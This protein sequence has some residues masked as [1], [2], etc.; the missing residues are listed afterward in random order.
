MAS[1]RTLLLLAVAAA[2][3]DDGEIAFKRGD[4]AQTTLSG[5]T[6]SWTLIASSWLDSYEDSVPS[7]IR[8]LGKFAGPASRAVTWRQA[9]FSCATSEGGIARVLPTVGT[10]SPFLP[11]ATLASMAEFLS[12]KF[13]EGCST[14]LQASVT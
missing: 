10:A 1:T 13:D 7:S 11:W 12:S 3:Q 8:A 4:D 6:P 2:A 14:V 9:Y 5:P